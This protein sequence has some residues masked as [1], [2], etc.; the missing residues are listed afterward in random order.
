MDNNTF[1]Q[2]NRTEI[3]IGLEKEYKFFQISDSHIAYVDEKSSDV[4][5]KDNDRSFNGWHTT[6]REFATKFS[7][8][9]DERYDIQAH[10]LFEKLMD[11]ALDFNP[12]AVIFSGDIMDRVTDSNIRYLKDYIGSYPKK[13]IY[14]LGNHATHDEYGNHRNMYDRFEGL[15]EN[16]DFDIFDFGEF[17]IV[18]L[19]NGSKTVTPSQLE[20]LKNEIQKGKKILLV[21]HIPLRIGEFGKIMG[22]Q[23]GG[24]FLMGSDGDDASAFELN[25]LVEENASSFI[26]ILAGHIHTSVEHN[27]SENL[28]QYTTSSSLI[29]YGREIIIK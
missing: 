21:I 20:K 19:D 8:F 16:P 29:G 6:K 26:A 9:C 12:D 25:R 13:V 22:E 7:E 23:I 5:I 3:N 2:I 14:C 18:A 24:Y 17:E 11:Y 10:L 15:V 1:L 28:K 4:D 27:V